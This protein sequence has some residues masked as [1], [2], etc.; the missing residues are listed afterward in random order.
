MPAAEALQS[1]G[2]A[3]GSRHWAACGEL[4][5]WVI[6][7]AQPCVGL[8]KILGFQLSNTVFF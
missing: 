7:F 2:I 3:E 1:V 6:C 4:S 5:R 8:L